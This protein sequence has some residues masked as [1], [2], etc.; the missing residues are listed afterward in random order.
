M[1]V[2]IRENIAPQIG[3]SDYT[4]TCTIS[5]AE[6]LNT[7]MTYRWFK[8]INTPTRNSV[9]TN[10][11]VLSFSS[12]LKLSNAGNYTCQVSTV[13][14]SQN[15]AINVMIMWAVIMESKCE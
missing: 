14:E 12:P 3:L 4:L 15:P 13:R 10:T 2:Q 6:T 9:G 11:S 5:G 8:D 7:N 1:A